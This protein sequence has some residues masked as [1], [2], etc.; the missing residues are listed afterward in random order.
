M[1]AGYPYDVNISDNERHS[2]TSTLFAY[3]SWPY[4]GARSLPPKFRPDFDLLIHYL[5]NDSTE[6]DGNVLADVPSPKGV[7]GCGMWK[8]ASADKSI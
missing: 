2:H 3:A 7:S 8:L 1:T 4:G 6:G 5:R